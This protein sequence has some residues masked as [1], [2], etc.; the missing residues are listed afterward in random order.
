AARAD[1]DVHLFQD[2]AE[3]ASRSEGRLMV[4]GILHQAFDEYA[5]RL[6]RE[7][8]DEWIKIQGRYLDVP[9]NLAAEEQ[10]DLIGRAI[11]ISQ[12][13]QDKSAA[14][15]AVAKSL[16]SQRFGNVSV[17]EARL[18]ACWPLHPLV[19]ALLGPISRRRFGQNQRSLFG[20]L[21]SVEPYGFQSYLEETEL[22]GARAYQ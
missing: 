2:L 22:G 21:N 1:G 4:V 14:T 12:P 16:S 15:N 6:A 20:F 18:E 10:L 8:R 13:I 3:T 5:H 7:A 11:E 9:I 17:L 19:A